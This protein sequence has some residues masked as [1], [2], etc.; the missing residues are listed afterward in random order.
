[1][2][3]S[4]LLSF[5]LLILTLGHTSQAALQLILDPTIERDFLMDGDRVS[6]ARD[7]VAVR[8]RTYVYT[9]TTDTSELASYRYEW[10]LEVFESGVWTAVPLL[11]VAPLR[12]VIRSLCI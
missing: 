2:P 8:M 6:P 11:V 3:K 7:G 12:P 10:T 1:M 4:R 5:C 9:N